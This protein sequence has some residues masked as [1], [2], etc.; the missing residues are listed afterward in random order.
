LR[1]KLFLNFYPRNRDKIF[2]FLWGWNKK[3]IKELQ[4]GSYLSIPLR[5]KLVLWTR[6]DIC[7][8]YLF[9][10]LWGWNPIYGSLYKVMPLVVFQFL[11]GWN[12]Y[13]IVSPTYA[14]I[15]TFNSFEDE[16]CG[17]ISN[18]IWLR[19]P[20][21]QFLWGWNMVQIENI[22]QTCPQLSIPLRMKHAVLTGTQGGTTTTTFN[23]FEDET[24][25]HTLIEDAGGI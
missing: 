21:F 19:L 2:Q 13:T 5:M 25:L 22:I 9:Q 12:R 6:R 7:H 8:L 16:T 14:P 18:C 10:F 1:M 24:S 3:S 20:I 17:S 15:S 4:S 23:S 11:W